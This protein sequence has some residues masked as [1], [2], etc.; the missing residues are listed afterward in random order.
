[1]RDPL[2]IDT[3][4][5]MESVRAKHYDTPETT[6]QVW[7]KAGD[8]SGWEFIDDFDSYSKASECASTLEGKGYK[9]RVED[10]EGN[11]L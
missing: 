1:M 7:V 6:F 2:D 11:V 9:V 8:N 10:G 4:G 3:D 5:Y